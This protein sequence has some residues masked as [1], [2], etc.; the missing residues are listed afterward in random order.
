MDFTGKNVRKKGGDDHLEE[1]ATEDL[2]EEIRKL[3]LRTFDEHLEARKK[4]VIAA[5]PTRA[6]KEIEG[7]APPAVSSAVALATEVKITDRCIRSPPPVPE[8][9]SASGSRPRS[10]LPRRS[11]PRRSWP[12]PP[13]APPPR[14]FPS[15]PRDPRQ[16]R[17]IEKVPEQVSSSVDSHA[18]TAKRQLFCLVERVHTSSKV[19]ENGRLIAAV[20]GSVEQGKVH[21]EHVL[22][23]HILFSSSCEFC[24]RARGLEPARSIRREDGGAGASKEVQVDKLCYKGV[25]LLVFVLV[26]CFAI[27]SCLYRSAE[28]QGGREAMIKDMVMWGRSVGLSGVDAKDISIS[29]RSDGEPV[30]RAICQDFAKELVAGSVEVGIVPVGGHAQSADRAVRTLKEGCNTLCASLESVGIEPYGIGIVYIMSHVA[31]AHTRYSIQ[32][33][34]ALTPEQRCLKTTRNPHPMYVWGASVLASPPPSLVK[35]V[36]GRFGNAVYLG[37]EVGSASHIVQFRLH[38][39]SYKVARSA[40]IRMIVP[41]TFE[42]GGL[43]GIC[44][45][46]KNRSAEAQRALPDMK[47]ENVRDVPIPNSA[48]RGPLREWVSEHGPTPRCRSCNIRGIDDSKAVHTQRCRD[49]YAEFLRQSFN[50]DPILLDEHEKDFNALDVPEVVERAF[51]NQDEGDELPPMDWLFPP[52]D[53]DIEYRLEVGDDYEP[54]GPSVVPVEPV[55]MVG[56]DVDADKLNVSPWRGHRIRRLKA[57]VWQYNT[58]CRLRT[59]IWPMRCSRRW[60]CS[61]VGTRLLFPVLFLLATT[62]QILRWIRV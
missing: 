52:E 38:D 16:H 24:V 9:A 35:E 49:R 19:A 40:R 62:S 18:A 51:Q 17:C 10:P 7:W 59:V 41:L 55:E 50:P 15:P 46:L 37:P 21:R 4:A 32:P 25:W 8:V 57:I 54:A 33:G 53:E 29:V 11:P 5:Q 27:G 61:L 2:R 20:D 56:D 14:K 6:R 43:R 36:H 1:F 42:V 26:G 34:S 48:T 23:S 3:L 60:S 28:M 44:R 31:Q 30:V 58:G 45:L 47:A 12:P 13:L 39:G 22:K